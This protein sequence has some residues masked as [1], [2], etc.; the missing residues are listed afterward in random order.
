MRHREADV[1]QF[2]TDTAIP[3]TS[4][5]VERELRPS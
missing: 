5:Q 2:L 4:D 1:L 3:P